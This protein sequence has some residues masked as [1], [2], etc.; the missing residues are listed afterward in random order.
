MFAAAFTRYANPQELLHWGEDETPHDTEDELKGESDP[1]ED[2]DLS[3]GSGGSPLSD[4]EELGAR[5]DDDS[6]DSSSEGDAEDEEATRKAA[7][8]AQQLATILGEGLDEGNAVEWAR[9]E[10]YLAAT[11]QWE[12]QLLA[13]SNRVAVAGLQH[14][15]ILA[16]ALSRCLSRAQL[17]V[18]ECPKASQAKKRA[19]CGVALREALWATSPGS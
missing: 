9:V 8:L 11:Q 15:P 3:D 18:P 12:A 2:N 10:Y 13:H 4:S 16:A 5:F 1:E 6:D 14:N 19:E 17:L 7:P